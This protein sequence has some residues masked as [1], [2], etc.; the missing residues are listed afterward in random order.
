LTVVL[1]CGGA[2]MRLRGYADDIP[3]PM[4]NI[5]SRPIVW[6][7]MKY[8]AHFGHTRF[9]LCLGYKGNAIKDYFLH[10]DESVSNDFVWSEGGKRI[11]FLSRDIDNWEITFVETGAN[12]TIA[13]RL[14]TVE[15][16]L[17]ND[18]TFL[19]NY[20]DGLSDVDLPAVIEAFKRTGAVASLLLVQPTASFD[21]VRVAED[22]KVRDICEL[23]R[24]EIWINGGFFVFRH[25][26]F[27]F[28]EPGDE[29]VR[30]PFR[31]L[32]DRNQLLA[33][34]Y[35]GFWQC[36]DTFKDKQILDELESSGAAPW[37][38]WKGG[39]AGTSRASGVT[40]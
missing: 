22:G 40:A 38:V 14:K 26:I 23:N 21:I 27:N 37:C 13:E 34:K 9:I 2:G 16:Y 29:L 8:Y 15:P 31:R 5:G 18:E 3:K 24:S 25:D 17:Q 10:Y 39:C 36:M 4:V 33:Y 35:G 32:I 28:I 12:A 30:E 11:Q 20:S 7:L 1:F 6:H 19:A